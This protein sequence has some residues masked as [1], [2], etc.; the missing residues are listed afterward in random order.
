MF[1]AL[2]IVLARLGVNER[3]NLDSGKPRRIP[4]A[5]NAGLVRVRGFSDVWGEQ[6]KRLFLPCTNPSEAL[7]RAADSEGGLSPDF[8]PA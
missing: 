4:E 8:V 2:N 7:M 6:R 3:K 1:L 5:I